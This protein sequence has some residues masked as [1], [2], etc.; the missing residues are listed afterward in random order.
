[1]LKRVLP[2]KENF[3]TLAY[4]RILI[5][6]KSL[7]YILPFAFLVLIPGIYY[8]IKT[9]ENYVA[10]FDI[11]TYIT[12]VSLIFIN[13]ISITI[14]KLIFTVMMFHLS[15]QLFF[16]LDNITVGMLY[17]LISN[18]SIALLYSKRTTL[19]FGVFNFILSVIIGLLIAFGNFHIISKS[20]D[21]LTEW[22]VT[23]LNMQF[24][25]IIISILIDYILIKLQHVIFIQ[26]ET[27]KNLENSVLMLQNKNDELEHMTYVASHDLQEPLRMVTSFL[28]Q[29]DK[30]YKDQLDQRGK[31]YIHFAM[32]GANKMRDVMLEV[33][34]FSKIGMNQSK[35]E[36]VNINEL[37]DE[38]LWMNRK[39]IQENNSQFIID[40]FP[41]VY[42]HKIL[43]RTL[44]TNLISNAVKYKS[45]ARISIIKMSYQVEDEKHVFKI[46][47]NGI[48][49]HPDKLEQIF[50]LFNRGDYKN[51][52][53]QGSGL[54]LAICKKIILLMKG[55]IH[56]ESTLHEG[57]TFRLKFPKENV[58]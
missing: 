17:W 56:V 14:K 36:E 20:N 10:I 12:I 57:S 37:V 53:V 6:Y 28:A 42:A 16:R 27:H 48:G 45:N 34:A 8:S 35:Q 33:L 43:L 47:D 21:E 52:Q 9:G 46:T 7:I 22:V 51:N 2:E 55:N 25:N 4:L 5:F 31:Q 1:M 23:S 50:L 38:V 29:L 39:L 54:G 32:D 40:Q 13:R 30:K 19:F 41:I 58:K 15:F 26:N 24:L 44:F 11:I 3:T 49:I 18:I